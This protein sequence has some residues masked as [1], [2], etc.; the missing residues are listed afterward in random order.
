LS[1]PRTHA[2]IVALLL[3][4]ASGFSHPNEHALSK[5]AENP[6]INCQQDEIKL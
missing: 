6:I 1:P 3:V 2:T 5:G 4:D